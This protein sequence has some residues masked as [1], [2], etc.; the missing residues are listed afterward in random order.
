MVT[1]FYLNLLDYLEGGGVGRHSCP[2]FG[3]LTIVHLLVHY[4]N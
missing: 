4:I 1:K 2:L 3:Y